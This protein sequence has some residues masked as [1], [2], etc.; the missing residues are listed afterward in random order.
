MLVDT[1]TN[2]QGAPDIMWWGQAFYFNDQGE[3]G[4]GVMMSGNLSI[5]DSYGIRVDNVGWSTLGGSW[6]ESYISTMYWS[7]CYVTGINAQTFD[8]YR[9]KY[10]NQTCNPAPPTPPPDPGPYP[11]DQ[12]SGDEPCNRAPICTPL[13]LDLQGG[14]YRFS[15]AHQGVWFD[16]NADGLLEKTAW[17]RDASVGF[18]FIDKNGNGLPDDGSELFGNAMRMKSGAPA[19]NGFQ[20]LLEYDTNGDHAITAADHRWNHLRLWFDRNRDG[21][22]AAQEIT[23]IQDAGVRSLEI[24]P[25]W[26]GRRDRYGNVLRWKAMFE[27][28]NA[29]SVHRRPYYDIYLTVAP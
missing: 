22:A 4:V 9:L 3:I 15:E 2:S 28:E 17:P 27:T 5:F 7:N 19:S 20:A 8:Q 25:T 11:I 14:D 10:G 18:L 29:G 23:G 24:D 16:L 21:Q 6:D 13:V 1:G 26:T 12:P